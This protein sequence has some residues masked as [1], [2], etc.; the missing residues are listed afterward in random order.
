MLS[1][2]PQQEASG[3]FG[4]LA[5]D[6]PFGEV[7][8]E[9]Y[10][11]S[12]YCQG[13]QSYARRGDINMRRGIALGELRRRSSGARNC[14]RSITRDE[15]GAGLLSMRPAASAGARVPRQRSSAREF[16]HVRVVIALE[17]VTERVGGCS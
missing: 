7:G 4:G 8:A 14:A 15:S 16:R 11:T 17:R 9:L 13:K 1:S 3:S 6:F 10:F 5:I 12:N 2:S